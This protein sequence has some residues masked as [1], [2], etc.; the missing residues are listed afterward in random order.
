MNKQFTFTL[1]DEPYKTST[2]QNKTV[3][4]TYTGPRYLALCVIQQTGEIKY[5]ARRGE[6]ETELDFE[7]LVDDDPATEFVKLDAM[8]HTFE[9][10]YL[11]GMYTTPE[12]E[13]YEFERPDGSK[14]V[15]H[16]DDHHGCIGQCMYG[17]DMKYING[18]YTTP[19]YREHALTRESFI[20]SN[21][22]LANIIRNSVQVNSYSAED[23]A[24]LLEHA[25]WLDNLETTYA[26]MDHWKIPFS[27]DIP[28][29]Y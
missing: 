6:L 25:T 4:V 26:N 28:N 20:Q 24:A 27:T 3:E 9:A 12:V 16:Y 18:A 11:T 17:Q 22:Q 8:T 14:Y 5:V 13:D 29:Y 15:Y 10:A 1:P 19:G 21:T 23:A 7:S 2:S